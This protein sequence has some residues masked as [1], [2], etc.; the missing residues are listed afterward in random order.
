MPTDN[1][2]IL[3]QLNAYIIRDS[4]RKS[5]LLA[6]LL[7]PLKATQQN[8]ID[9]AAISVSLFKNKAA[10]RQ[11]NQEARHQLYHG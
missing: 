3:A 4:H 8:L 1:L 6:L 2:L 10:R 7:D 5:D 9:F 11:I